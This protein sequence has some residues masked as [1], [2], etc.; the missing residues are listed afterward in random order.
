MNKV[1][2]KGKFFNIKKR[3]FK[4]FSFFLGAAFVFLLLSKLSES[5][6]KQ[7]KL[8][9]EVFNLDDEVVVD[10]DSVPDAVVTI[11]SKGFSL[12]QFFLSDSKTIRL[13]AK[14]DLNKSKNQYFWDVK[15]NIYKL[16]T[17]FGNSV[18][19]LGVE[20]DTIRI[21]YSKLRTKILPVELVSDLTFSSG[22]DVVG[23]I[24]M[25]ND[26]V[27]VIG[28]EN[29]IVSLESIK[30]VPL[31]LKDIKGNVEANLK[32]E[33]PKNHTIVPTEVKIKAD[34]SIFTEGQVSLPIEVINAPV[35]KSI[36]Y[37]PKRIN[38]IYYIDIENFKTVSAEDFRIIADFNDMDLN[39]NK[40]I[41]LKVIDAPYSIKRYRLQQS[42]IQ[43]IIAD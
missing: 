27:K 13:D 30:T 7:V 10:Y 8:D 6:T 17:V 33:A 2:G 34:V 29:E 15:S 25:S 14:K 36:N 5:Y 35:D 1:K 39:K 40:S 41:E 26:S 20:P 42:R 24:I 12:L 4:L 43:F 38:L 19:V 21:G 32:L 16:D 11:N 3:S 31:V 9:V 37:F 23:D 22:Y 18:E 28:S